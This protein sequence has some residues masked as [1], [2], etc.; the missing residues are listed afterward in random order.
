MID[1][2]VKGIIVSD[3][4]ILLLKR[5][6]KEDCF[7]A[8]WDIPGG[9]IAFGEDLNRALKREIKEESDIDA[10]VIIPFST[11]SFFRNENTYVVGITFLCKLKNDKIQINLSKEH[12][13]FIWASKDDLDKLN[14]NENLKN[15]LKEFFETKFYQKFQL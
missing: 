15:N 12:E 2:A 5:S 3:E 14:M 9:K 13:Q 1:V 6:S 10:E 11:W 8:L 7:P 4:K